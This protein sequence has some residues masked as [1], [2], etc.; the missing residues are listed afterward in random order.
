MK[1]LLNILLA[2]ITTFTMFINTN[3]L[4]SCSIVINDDNKNAHTYEI[5]QV[6]TGTISSDGRTLSNI[7][8]GESVKEEFKSGKNAYDYAKTITD[9]ATAEA[10]LTNLGTKMSKTFTYDSN[11]KTYTVDGLA[12]GYYFI[13]DENGSVT[14][15]DDSYSEYII[16][17]LND[18]SISR[19]ASNPTAV[20]KIVEGTNKV[21]YTSNYAVGE[22]VN[23]ELTGTLP[24]QERYAKYDTYKYIFHDTLNDGLDLNTS[25]I[26]VFVDGTE[27]STGFTKT[28]SNHA[29]DITFANTKTGIKDTNGN[30]VTI[31][32]N[33]K[34]TVTYS[35]TIN[36]NAV[37]GIP[38]NDNTLVIEYSNN[39]YTNETGET[40]P[41]I[42]KVYIFD[43]R[44][45]KIANNTNQA[46]PGAQFKL[47]RLNSN[48]NQW[49]TVRG[50]EYVVGQDEATFTFK[51]LSTGKY[52]LT[53]TVTPNGYNTITPV[54]FEITATYDNNGLKTLSVDSVETNE[55][56]KFS[57]EEQDPEFGSDAT[58]STVITTITNIKGIDLPLTGGIGTTL[59]TIFGI[60][61]MVFAIVSFV[62]NKK[63][64]L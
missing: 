45:N 35:A 13:K 48:N 6:F 34:I 17:I 27:I 11:A 24:S 14:G 55:V 43:L 21:D 47:E 9:T 40:T 39:P 41:E 29:F 26:K 19:K 23:Y 2:F 49:E 7:K 15:K 18:V 12:P 25:S 46:L 20:K 44:F 28:T 54:I 60:V 63:E 57:V 62:K 51:G 22:T 1:K 42:V 8:W 5:Y 59:F 30:D 64:K 10:I 38:G 50:I 4:E 53:E 37:R 61:L 3:A 52:K 36:S 16:Q 56:A 32:Y 58:L 31:A 33:S